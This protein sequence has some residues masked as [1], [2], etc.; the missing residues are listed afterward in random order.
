MRC[1]E[2]NLCSATSAK[3]NIV[4]KSTVQ[5]FAINKCKGKEQDTQIYTLQLKSVS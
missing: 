4:V 2:I 3:E 1:L 5:G